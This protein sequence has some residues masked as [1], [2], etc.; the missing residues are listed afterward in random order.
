M[1]Y[2]ISGNNHCSFGFATNVP[3]NDTINVNE[4]VNEPLNLVYDVVSKFPYLSK[5]KIAERIGKSR[6]T[7]T[8]ALAQLVNKGLI[9]KIGSDKKGYWKI[10]EQSS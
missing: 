7:V 2:K 10:L 8:R 6:A 1:L 3:V 9:R 4:P 5:E